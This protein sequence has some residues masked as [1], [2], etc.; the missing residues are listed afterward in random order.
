MDKLEKTQKFQK[1]L[2]EEK[3][4]AKKYTEKDFIEEYE[5]DTLQAKNRAEFEN[6]KLKSKFIEKFG[7]NFEGFLKWT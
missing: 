1:E 5:G 3:E 6:N 2:Y 4:E 7:S